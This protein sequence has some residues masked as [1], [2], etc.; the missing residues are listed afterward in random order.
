MTFRGPL[1]PQPA[2]HYTIN[3]TSAARALAGSRIDFP[4][5][6]RGVRWREFWTQKHI[7]G[8]RRY[9]IKEPARAR[10]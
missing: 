6:A 5:D 10:L 1:K 4:V 2:G 9:V 8:M 3:E 7:P